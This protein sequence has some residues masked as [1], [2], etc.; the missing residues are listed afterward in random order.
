M[1]FI[2]GILHAV[3]KIYKTEN[4]HT[5]TIILQVSQCVATN[6]V[7]DKYFRTK[8]FFVQCDKNFLLHDKILSI[9]IPKKYWLSTMVKGNSQ[10]RFP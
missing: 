1:D 8:E 2:T 3:K 7:S 9:S 4:I 5:L 6:V 10:A